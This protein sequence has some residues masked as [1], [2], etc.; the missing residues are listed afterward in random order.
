MKIRN[1]FIIFLVSGFWHGANWTFII[2]GFLNA[3]YFLPL[4]LS[5]SNRQNITIVAQGKTFPSVRAFF[6]MLFTFTL[7]VFAWIFFR[8]AT[9]QDAFTYIK[10]IFTSSLFTAPHFED[11]SKVKITLYFL[12]FFLVVE[13]SG[14][15]NNYALETIGFKWNKYIRRLFYAILIFL[16]GMYMQTEETPFIYFQF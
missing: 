8:A 13:W 5:N 7:T 3:L 10:G 15:A 11:L 16:I 2:W 6:A 9:L 1:T 14:R 12:M 4:L